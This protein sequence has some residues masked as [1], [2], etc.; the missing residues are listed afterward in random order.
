MFPR[1]FRV[2]RKD[3]CGAARAEARVSRAPSVPPPFEMFSRAAAAAG[4]GSARCRRA[5]A[6]APSGCEGRERSRRRAGARRRAF[7]MSESAPRTGRPPGR[8]PQGPTRRGGGGR[9]FRVNSSERFRGEGAEAPPRPSGTWRG[10]GRSSGPARARTR[11]RGERAALRL[12]T[13]S[14]ETRLAE[15]RRPER[16]RAQR[17]PRASRAHPPTCQAGAAPHFASGAARAA[18][19]TQETVSHRCRKR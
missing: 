7:D 12:T 8:T 4:L 14:P 10:A 1:A 19:H 6:P 9:S 17:R 11:P 18:H 13:L 15:K 16:P 3:S 5:R 2:D